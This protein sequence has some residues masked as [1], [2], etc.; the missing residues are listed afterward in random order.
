VRAAPA[1]ARR[2]RRRR[3]ASGGRRGPTSA[4]QA[5]RTRPVPPRWGRARSAAGRSRRPA[6]PERPAH[7]RRA[8]DALGAHRTPTA[9][10][11]QH[12]NTPRQ[13]PGAAQ[14]PQPLTS[15]GAGAAAAA[16]TMG[17]RRTPRAGPAARPTRGRVAVGRGRVAAGRAAR[18][19]DSAAPRA[20][21]R[22]TARMAPGSGR[23]V[24][25]AAAAGR[26]GEGR[27]GVGRR[28]GGG[29]APA[30]RSLCTPLLAAALA[31][32]A[33]VLAACADPASGRCVA[34]HGGAHSFSA[35]AHRLSPLPP[36][37]SPASSPSLS[38]PPTPCTTSRCEWGGG[39]GP[40]EIG[41]ASCPNFPPA[42]STRPLLLSQRAVALRLGVPANVSVSASRGGRP[43]DDGGGAKAACAAVG[44]E[45]VTAW[46]WG[47]ER[48]DGCG[49]EARHGGD[50][51]PTLQP[52]SPQR[53]ASVRVPN[54][55]ASTGAAG[56]ASPVSSGPGWA[57][58][59]GWAGGGSARTPGWPLLAL[60]AALHLFL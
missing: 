52:S 41:A 7:G 22:A 29:R 37:A 5:R 34:G 36:A 40:R 49:S 59:V 10:R 24:A 4:R 13:C 12:G 42:A 47:T 20:G 3:R 46:S 58:A 27:V 31:D 35:I 28:C 8:R 53:S 38:P 26:G 51:H 55:W 19:A 57:A 16:R 56:R 60:V 43:L 25:G 6:S 2:R 33:P 50:D 11:A 18:G 32:L 54:G 45:P 44:R 9:G 21:E 23:G 1:P 30:D 14:P 15:F 17:T 48:G 39:G